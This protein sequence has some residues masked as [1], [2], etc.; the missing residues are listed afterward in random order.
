MLRSNV[1]WG[2][3]EDPSIL[4]GARGSQALSIRPLVQVGTGGGGYKPHSPPQ[5]INQSL[6]VTNPLTDVEVLSMEVIETNVLPSLK[7]LLLESP[8]GSLP[9]GGRLKHF[10][11]NWE[12]ITTDHTILE[13]VKGYKIVF[14][15]PPIQWGPVHTPRFSV[16]KSTHLTQEV[17]E[18]LTKNAIEECSPLPDQFVGHLLLRPKNNGIFRPVFNLKPLNAFVVYQHIKMEGVQMLTSMIQTHDWMMTIYLKDAYFCVPIAG[19]H[20]KYLRF[21]WNGKLYQFKSLPFG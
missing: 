17:E 14:T 3:S 1:S 12:Q 7:Y 13:T 10:H 15:Q 21:H 9:L 16:E 19:K 20:C 18:M 2:V 4:D 11:K 5:L 6:I 8:E